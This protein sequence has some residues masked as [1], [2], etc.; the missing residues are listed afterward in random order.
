MVD[1]MEALFAEAIKLRKQSQPLEFSAAV[2]EEMLIWLQENVALDF[3]WQDLQQKNQELASLKEGL[4]SIV[5]C[6]FFF[7]NFFLK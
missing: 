7:P 2:A 6:I 4:K 5:G 3:L 1:Q